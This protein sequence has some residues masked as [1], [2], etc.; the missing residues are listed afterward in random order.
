MA[1][2]PGPVVRYL[3]TKL[4][5]LVPVFTELE[6][7]RDKNMN[8]WRVSGAYSFFGST[9]NSFTLSVNSREYAAVIFADAQHLLNHASEHRAHVLDNGLPTEPSP[10]WT[11]VSLYYFSLFIAMAWSRVSNSSV[12][13]LDKDS[14]REFCGSAVT[15]PGGGAFCAVA[16]T[17]PTTGATLVEFK[18]A[19]ATHFHEAAWITLHNGIFSAEKWVK[20][21]SASRK[22]TPEE[23]LALRALRLFSGFTFEDPLTWPSRLRNAVNYRPG[24]SYRSVIKHNFLKIRSKAS[25]PAYASLDAV[26]SEGEVAKN[27]LRGATSILDFPNEAV[28]LLIAQSLIVEKFTEDAL[29]NICTIQNLSCSARRLRVNYN[30]TMLIRDSMLRPLP[31]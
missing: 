11:F 3:S 13:Y 28:S 31:P 10:S 24:Y 9:K 26:I 18:K 21:L 17:D 29:L 12:L 23:E 6:P 14:I 20:D 30:K 16:T 7:F 27:S 19:S 22:A 2:N 8:N 1:K 5:D 4:I 25:R 15:V